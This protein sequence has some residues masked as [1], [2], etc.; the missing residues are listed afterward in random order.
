MFQ[1]C[2]YFHAT[3]SRSVAKNADKQKFKEC[4]KIE[5]KQ[6]FRVFTYLPTNEVHMLR[7]AY[8]Q[9]SSNIKNFLP[10]IEECANIRETHEPCK[11]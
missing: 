11:Y 7:H 2:D 5:P 3:V 10:L 9:F 1:K 6:K 8:I 4:R